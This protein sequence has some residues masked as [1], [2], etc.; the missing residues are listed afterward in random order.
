[1]AM[2]SIANS[3]SRVWQMFLR[4]AKDTTS[5]RKA[6]DL[7]MN[8]FKKIGC[9]NTLSTQLTLARQVEDQTF[10][11]AMDVKT[12]NHWLSRDILALTGP[13]PAERQELFD[14][15]VAK[16]QHR[17]HRIR[18]AFIRCARRWRNN[19]TIRWRSPRC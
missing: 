16:L 8:A 13:A 14:F 19:A 6:L 2:S 3:N 9:G 4:V 10:Q 18:H 12:L 11:L 15:I 5:R 7:K 17:E 1:M